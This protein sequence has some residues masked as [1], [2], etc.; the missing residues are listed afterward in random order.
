MQCQSGTIKI[1]T[2]QALICGENELVTARDSSSI[3]IT[4]H[5][6]CVTKSLTHHHNFYIPYWAELCTERLPD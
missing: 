6:R 2:H 1:H 3:S 5:M 4:G